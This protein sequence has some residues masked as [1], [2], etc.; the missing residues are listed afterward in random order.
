L[1]LIIK[2]KKNGCIKRLKTL[3]KTIGDYEKCNLR[4]SKR[5]TKKLIFKTKTNWEKKKYG[6]EKTT[7]SKA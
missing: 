7:S 5:K 2:K 1:Y 6:R 3:L 4:V